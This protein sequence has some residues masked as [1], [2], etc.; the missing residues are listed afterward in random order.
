VTTVKDDVD[1]LYAALTGDQCALT[2]IR[3]LREDGGDGTGTE[4]A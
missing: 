3:V 2:D 1:D 4:R